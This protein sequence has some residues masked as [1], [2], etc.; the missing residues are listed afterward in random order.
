MCLD[1]VNLKEKI[2]VSGLSH[3]ASSDYIYLNKLHMLT[4]AFPVC[5]SFGG[6]CPHAPDL[7]SNLELH[8]VSSIFANLKI[9]I[10]YN[11]RMMQNASNIKDWADQKKRENNAAAQSEKDEDAAYAAQTNAI[12]RMRGL[13]ED[14]A[15]QKRN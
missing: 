11:D 6:C 13:L 14:E 15:T 1:A 7:S 2:S 5:L 3:D 4:K 10:V 8:I 9:F 12:L